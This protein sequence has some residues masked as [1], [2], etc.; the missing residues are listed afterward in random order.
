MWITA[1]GNR[2]LRGAEWE[3]FRVGLS[4]LWDDIESQE[5][6]EEPGT[7][8]MDGFDRL[9]R[10]ERL[11]LLAQVAKG[12]HDRGEPCADLTAPNEAAVAAV[13]AQVRYLVSVE[14]DGQRSG[15]GAFSRD[16]AGRPRERVPAAIR[17][18]EP[19]LKADLP[20]ASSTDYSKWSDLIRTMP[21]RILD[22]I[23][24]LATDVFLD[25]ARSRGRSMKAVLGIPH[26]YFSA[27]PYSPTRRQLE[28]IRADLRRICGRP[29]AWLTPQS[30]TG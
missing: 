15:F 14:I 10:P 1:L 6:D 30:S 19:V 13:F 4:T 25:M 3:L 27:V 7:T 18:V 21:F 28:A 29:K 16:R 2:V 22:D 12:L 24:Y 23:D 8:G 20:K 9:S 26:D 17:Q 11:A 5:D